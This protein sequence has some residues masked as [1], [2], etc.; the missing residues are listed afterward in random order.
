[1]VNLE[2]LQ[3]ERLKEIKAHMNSLTL[4]KEA[5]ESTLE[6]KV[7][8]QNPDGT[9]TRFTKIDNIEELKKGEFYR[10]T[11]ITQFTTKVEILKHQPKEKE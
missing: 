9:W 10:S 6:D 8:Y 2:G 11:R 3:I 5:I 4:E 1:M 7:I